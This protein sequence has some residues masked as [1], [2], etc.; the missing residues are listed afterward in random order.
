MDDNK[1]GVGGAVVAELEFRAKNEEPRL[2][3]LVV[4][5][6]PLK[7]RLRLCK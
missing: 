5:S 7:L 6:P 1:L 4:L 3:E 2:L